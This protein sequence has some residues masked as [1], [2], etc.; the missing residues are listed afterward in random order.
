MELVLEQLPI[1]VN[2]GVTELLEEVT[3]HISAKVESLAN[4][5]GGS[6]STPATP[7][8]IKLALSPAN[9]QHSLRDYGIAWFNS[10]QVKASVPSDLIYDTAFAKQVSQY[11][12]TGTG[13]GQASSSNW[14]RKRAH[15]NYTPARANFPEE[16]QLDPPAKSVSK[17]DRPKLSQ[18]QPQANGFVYFPLDGTVLSRH[19]PVSVKPI[20]EQNG[21]N[22]RRVPDQ[23]L[24]PSE[25]GA[26]GKPR[27]PAKTC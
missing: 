12:T 22:R 1:Q 3:A 16:M 18:P 15:P 20:L 2:N 26:D 8:A 17:G 14:G 6:P 19:L 25:L 21:S 23:F 9:R 24:I 27:R 11:G 4:L 10:D 7:A 13:T 5:I